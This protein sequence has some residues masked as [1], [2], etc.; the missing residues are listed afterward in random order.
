M[1]RTVTTVTVQRPTSPTTVIRVSR[2]A[3]R[4][5]GAGRVAGGRA[6][7]AALPLAPPARARPRP[8]T[9]QWSPQWSALFFLA[10][11]KTASYASYTATVTFFMTIVVSA[12]CA[13]R[14]TSPRVMCPES[15][16]LRNVS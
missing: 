13:M 10:G 6:K 9:P 11:G 2:S 12:T 14:A 4:G 7:P 8:T 3:G 5:C 1:F 16:C 15:Y